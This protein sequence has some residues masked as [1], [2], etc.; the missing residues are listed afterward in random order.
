[1]K[2]SNMHAIRRTTIALSLLALASLTA[3]TS[4]GYRCPLD[5]NEKAESSTA[6]KG[7]EDAMTGAKRGSGGHTSVFLDDQ[8]RIIPRELIENRAAS[9]LVNNPAGNGAY[10]AETGQPVFQQAK[11]FK[12]YTGAYQDSE[13]HL[14]DGQN[15]WFTTQ[16]RWTRGTLDQPGHAGQNLLRPANPNERPAG[17]IVNVDRNGNLVVPA[18]AQPVNADQVKKEAD[19][20]ALKSLSQAANA[21]ATKATAP[22]AKA[23]PQ[24]AAGVTAPAVLLGN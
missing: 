1:M 24:S 5:P 6:C 14:F 17:R 19:A 8:G 15:S 2:T 13:G 18:K 22:A 23:P 3:C 4:I 21:S 16:G 20:A 9:P 10:Y 7:M 12:A 11:V